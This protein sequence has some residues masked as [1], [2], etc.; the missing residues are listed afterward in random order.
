[1]P[2]MTKPTCTVHASGVFSLFAALAF[3]SREH[4]ARTIVFFDYPGKFGSRNALL[5][6]IAPILNV[7]D[8]PDAV[9]TYVTD[10][11]QVTA[12][13]ADIYS[14]N[15]TRILFAES[16]Q[17]KKVREL[18]SS[19]SPEQI[20]FYAEGAMSFGPIREGLPPSLARDLHSVHYV[21][22]SGL[23]PLAL[24]QFQ[25][26]DA[27]MSSGEFREL[28]LKL[29]DILDANY[30][31]LTEIDQFLASTPSRGLVLVHQN[32]S[33]IAGLDLATERRIF[34]GIQ[35]QIMWFGNP[36]IFMHPKS[37]GNHSDIFDAQSDCV[38]VAPP[39]P[40]AEYYIHNLRPKLCVGLFSSSLL[41]L[42]VLDI[43][44]FTLG[45]GKVGHTIKSAFDSNVYALHFTQ[46]SL[47][48]TEHEGY[49]YPSADLDRL[50]E[51]LK[52]NDFA[53]CPDMTNRLWELPYYLGDVKALSDNLAQTECDWS[54]LGPFRTMPAFRR[55]SPFRKEMLINATLTPAEIRKRK[56][57]ASIKK[58]YAGIKK[59]IYSLLAKGKKA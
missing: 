55:L 45:A 3:A 2:P 29:F 54:A 8:I 26:K 10:E 27:G 15:D 51:R 59:Y 40:M 49:L 52:D 20:H 58:A 11:D 41:N 12:N 6:K 16:L 25:A 32:L 46:L 21:D 13:I 30:R 14:V 17:S 39:F 4:V 57:D 38:F 43:P 33:S 28:L 31:V 7:F 48:S 36:V 37:A 56:R 22:Y 9:V 19:L 34:S 47:G 50:I 53:R 35:K 18:I 24:K 1:M 23:K 42:K 5:A 44:V